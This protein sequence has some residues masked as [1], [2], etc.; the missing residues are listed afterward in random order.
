MAIKANQDRRVLSNERAV[1]QVGNLFDTVLVLADRMRELKSGATP[2]T[3]SG[4]TL[5]GT[6]YHEAEA[7]HLSRTRL[8]QRYK[9][10]R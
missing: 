9:R 1:R 2:F 3:E 8:I 6:V 4:P 5:L 10:N 7:G